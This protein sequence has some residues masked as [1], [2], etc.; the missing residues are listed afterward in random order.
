MNSDKIENKTVIPMNEYS[1]KYNKLL[2][3][4][5]IVNKYWTRYYFSMFCTL[6]IIAFSI[7]H[8]FF[9]GS[10]FSYFILIFPFIVLSGIFKNRIILFLY[11]M[12]K[13]KDTN[14]NI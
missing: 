2:D 13:K 10:F 11:K 5:K 6:G 14:S 9:K 12:F 1:E 3:D 7:S 8:V 4:I